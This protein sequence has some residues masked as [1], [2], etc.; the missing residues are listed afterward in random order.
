MRR[1]LPYLSTL[2]LQL[3]AAGGALLL[4]SL[5]WQTV[6]VRRAGPFPPAVVDLSGRDVDAASTALALVALAGAVAVVATR[7]RWRRAVG[8]VVALAGA[9]LVWRAVSSTSAIGAARARALVEARRQTVSVALGARPRI[10]VHAAWPALS[11]GC[12]V[13]VL[14]AGVLIAALG[15][16][17]QHMSS[18]YDASPEPGET[19]GRAAAAMWSALDRGEDPTSS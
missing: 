10:E 19:E 5:T 13:A 17:W 11:I 4:S 8:G 15:G 12:G 18:R 2:L 9:G 14:A 7:G 6:T 1:Y 3:A 16:R